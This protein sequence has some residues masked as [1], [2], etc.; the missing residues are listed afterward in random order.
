MCILKCAIRLTGN[1]ELIQVLASCLVFV[2]CFFCFSPDNV[3]IKFSS[4]LCAVTGTYCECVTNKEG[5][6]PTFI[7]FLKTQV[8]GKPIGFTKTYFYDL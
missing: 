1:C 4:H 6:N 5:C 8:W 2:F 7:L 3:G